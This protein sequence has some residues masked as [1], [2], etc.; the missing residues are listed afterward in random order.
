MKSL[1][2]NK[3][4]H[5][6]KGEFP[7]QV[8]AAAFVIS[9]LATIFSGWQS[10]RMHYL[11]EEMSARHITLTK[12]VGRIMLLDESL[13]M[14]ARMAAATGDINYEKRYNSVRS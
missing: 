3:N 14:S 12:R 6:D 11:F 13:T 4:K 9:L 5:R 7:L 10:W 2:L 1:S 8:F